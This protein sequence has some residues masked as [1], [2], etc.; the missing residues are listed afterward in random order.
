MLNRN[1]ILRTYF[2]T[3]FSLFALLCDATPAFAQPGSS[4]LVQAG[5]KQPNI[6]LIV[7]DDLGYGEL[8]CQGNPQIPTPAI[9]SLAQ[10]GVR[11]TQGY[12][13]A[14]NCSPS[15]A[16]LLTGRIPTRFGY[17]FNPI[18]ARNEDPHT[19]LPSSERTLAEALHGAGYT[20]GLVGKW[21]LG[22]A[23]DF[24][25]QR[26]GFDQFFGFIHE[27]HYFVPPPWDGTMTMLR[28]RNLP[29]GSGGR[30]TVSESLLYTSHMGH[31]EPAYDANNPIL[32]AGQ[33]VP[34][35][36][37]LT[38]AFARE[39]VDFIEHH[40]KGPFFLTVTFN[41][42][43]SPLQAKLPTLEKFSGIKDMHRRIF[44][45]MLHDLDTAV[46]RIVECIDRENLRDDTIIVFLSDNGGPT[47]EL[48]SSNL[49]LRGGKGSM[50]EGGLRVPMLVNW[51]KELPQGTV[52]NEIVSSLDFFPTLARLA[53]AELPKAELPNTEMPVTLDGHD[54][55]PLLKGD[56]S[57]SNHQFLFWRQGKRAAL[58][59]GPW[60]IVCPRSPSNQRIWELY[61]V[62]SDISETNN[63]A[64]SQPEKLEEL[65]SQ[66]EKLDAQ[67]EPPLF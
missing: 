11:C 45:A 60:K 53:G 35:S 62:E 29:A 34:E 23:A 31:N 50:Y 27:G 46:G 5:A 56:D 36:A 3:A 18:G 41:A 67:M 55:L 10:S 65:I 20:T 4:G 39:A 17:E 48:T 15:R 37:Y 42:V 52:C 43:H 19:G 7:A 59:A 9:D 6:V 24:H 30:F 64:S 47:K 38:D 16:G 58:R 22:G 8:G 32:R 61:H 57:M 28:K 44:A 12:V 33:P 13:T 1:R 51:P 26:H 21:H 2:T 49:P 14:P 40:A 63:M 66:W 25:P 54:I